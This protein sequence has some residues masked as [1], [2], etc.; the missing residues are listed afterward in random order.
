MPDSA[1]CQRY[2]L[3]RG[4]EKSDEVCMVSYVVFLASS[5]SFFVCSPPS[6]SW[7]HFS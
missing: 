6:M 7:G 3:N 2:I 1:D 4:I 5:L